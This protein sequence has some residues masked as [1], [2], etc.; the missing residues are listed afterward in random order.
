MATAPVLDPL[1]QARLKPLQVALEKDFGVSVTQKDLVNGLVYAATA[2][3]A[4]GMISEFTKARAARAAA[5]Q[6]E[7]EE[8]A[9]PNA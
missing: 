1:A 5:A 3:Q 6:A 8:D 7:A 9:E 4:V 2:A